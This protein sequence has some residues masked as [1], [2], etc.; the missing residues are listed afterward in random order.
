MDSTTKEEI[1]G[2]HIRNLSS[3]KL[4]IA[5]EYGKFRIPV[6]KGDTLM[7]SN[8][9]YQTLGW[10]ADESWFEK[11]RVEFLLPVDTVYLQEVVIGEFP[12][13]S[14]FKQMLVDAEVDDTSFWYHGV[15]Q[16]NM[17]EHTVMEKKEFTNP[18]FIATHPI[19]FLHNA[20]SKKEK[21]KRKMQQISKNKNVTTK[22]RQKFTREWVGEMT[23]LKGDQLTDF[24]AFCKFTP[25][26]IAKT[27]LYMIHERMMTL[28]DDFMA[29]QAE[30]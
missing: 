22:A 16:P 29:K 12:D 15:P 21:E 2:T 5:D 11:E 19:S 24:I 6:Q 4:A 17:E 30:G 18:V 23:K 27:E 10:I 14:R 3:D 28:L 8:V 13:Y 26:Y 7:F 25:T 20:F 9:G 1:I